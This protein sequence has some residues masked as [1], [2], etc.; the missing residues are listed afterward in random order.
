MADDKT[1]IVS[2]FDEELTRLNNIISQMGGLAESQLIS[3]IR[4]IVKRDSELAEKV[5]LSDHRIDVLEQEVQD[6]AVR[7]LALRQPMAD[8]LRQVVTALKLSN[9]LER[10][11]DLAK[12]IAKRAQVLNQIPPI[13][14]VQVIPNMGKLAQ[15]IIKDVLDAYIEGDAEKAE[16]VWARDQEVDDMYNSLFREL[17]T[18]MMEDPRNITASTHMLFIAKNIERIGD[19]ATNIA[20][21]IYYRIKGEDLPAIDRPKNDAANFAVVEPNE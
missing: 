15:E 5:I 14:P 7:L 9:D 16:R 4:S 1:H 17:L 6:F 10:I 12:N 19:H 2:S 18:Y 21:T 8:D 13:R 3:A 20:E 11:G